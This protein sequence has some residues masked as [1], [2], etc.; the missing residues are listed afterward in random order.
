MRCL[1]YWS[2]PW[3]LG[4]REG[5]V[6][7]I[8]PYITGEV[9]GGTS[10]P[11]QVN[12]IAKQARQRYKTA[13]VTAVAGTI[14]TIAPGCVSQNYRLTENLANASPEQIWCKPV[15]AQRKEMTKL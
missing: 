3:R 14:G 8:S 11:G 5:P 1:L 7:S 9:L 2:M 4:K 6:G 10:S 13:C 12:K 15:C